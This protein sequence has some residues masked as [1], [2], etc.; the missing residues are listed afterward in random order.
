MSDEAYQKLFVQEAIVAY[1]QTESKLRNTC[2][3]E[4][5]IN[6]NQAVFLIAGSASGA[7]TTTRGPNGKIQSQK[8]NLVQKTVTLKEEHYKETVNDFDLRSTHGGANIRRSIMS[9]STMSVIHRKYD[10]Q[11]LQE[12]N[13][14]TQTAGA[15][16]VVSYS[17][18]TKAL[19][20]LAN[21]DVDITSNEIY[22]VITPAFYAKLLEMDQFTNIDYVETK[23][24]IDNSGGISS[25]IKMIKWLGVH[26]ITHTGLPGQ[27]SS[28]AS[29]FLYHKNSIGHGCHFT[30]IDMAMG[31]NSE[32]KYSY[33]TGTMHAEALKLQDEGIVKI[34]HDD[35][36]V[37]TA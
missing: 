26:W 37:L 4:T 2:I 15:A 24:I 34:L 14:A 19:A 13:T 10:D 35:N 17:K 7:T 20:L 9:R 27:G 30:G 25:T 12:L 28:S 8:S 16:A 22:G 11:I 29:C 31:Y 32:N 5:E 3:T 18:I 23:P 33:C 36:S 21:N 6:G 1:E